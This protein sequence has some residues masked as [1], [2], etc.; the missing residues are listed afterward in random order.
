MEDELSI[1]HKNNLKNN[2]IPFNAQKSV[3]S[4]KSFIIHQQFSRDSVMVKKL[5]SQTNCDWVVRFIL[6]RFPYMQSRAKM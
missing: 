2:L 6:T 5:I 1:F 4:K 3:V